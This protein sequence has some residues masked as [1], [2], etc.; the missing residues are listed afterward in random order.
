MPIFDGD[1]CG[2]TEHEDPELASGSVRTLDE[3]EEWP[4]SRPNCV[5]AWAP[6]VETGDRP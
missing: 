2:W 5:R 6:A 4:L 3:A 1:D